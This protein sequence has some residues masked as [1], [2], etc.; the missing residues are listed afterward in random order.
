MESAAAPNLGAPLRS[1]GVVKGT[2]SAED[3]GRSVVVSDATRS[4]LLTMD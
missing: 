3:A 4:A 2:S 1:C